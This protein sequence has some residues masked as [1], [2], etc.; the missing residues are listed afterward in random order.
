MMSDNFASEKEKKRRPGLGEEL[1]ECLDS[2][3]HKI[4]FLIG[5]LLWFG[6]FHF[7]G[8]STFGYTD[9]DSL[10]GWLDYDY[11]QKA[12]DEHG[13]LVPFAFLALIWFE[14]QRFIDAVKRQW[15]PGIILVLIGLLIHLAGYRVQQVRISVIGFFIGWYG[16]I[17]MFWGP[18]FLRAVFFPYIL[19]IFCF[20]IGSLSD[21]ISFPLRMMASTITE[22]LSHILG[23]DVIRRGTVLFNPDKGYEY[24]VAAACSGLRSLIAILGI[25]VVYGFLIFRTWWRRLLM[26]LSAFPL[27]VASNVCR[28]LMII[29]A[30]E[31]FGQQGGIYVH[32][33]SILS[34]VPYL[35]AFIGMMV[36]ARIFREKE[37][38]LKK[39]LSTGTEI[40]SEEE[41]S[42]AK[43]SAESVLE[44]TKEKNHE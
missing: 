27:A 41:H 44:S 28:L 7:F 10:F 3:P 37:P 1:R 35:I 34:M 38:N 18:A 36:L 29:I 33:S 6:A 42:A 2:F 4:L 16:I 43:I 14:K 13:Y 12:G 22:M 19:F 30:G 21:P 15:W 31:I 9:T 40:K 11:S 17:G 23:I 25:S 26:I 32:D 5:T 8:N 20:P 24:E 39:A